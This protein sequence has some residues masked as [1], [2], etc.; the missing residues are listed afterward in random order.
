MY[1]GPFT[2][3]G[4]IFYGTDLSLC[5]GILLFRLFLLH[6]CARFLF[7]LELLFCFALE[8]KFGIFFSDLLHGQV[9][10][11]LFN[12]LFVFLIESIP[13]LQPCIEALTFIRILLRDN[14]TRR[15]IYMIQMVVGFDLARQIFTIQESENK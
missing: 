10:W 9:P 12:R 6:R 2:W 11:I 8:K 7:L 15:G 4:L 13:A 5:G 14:L 3:S 1:G